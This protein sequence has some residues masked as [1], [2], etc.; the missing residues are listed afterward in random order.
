MYGYHD[1]WGWF[2]MVPM[3]LLW[4]AVWGG[5][6]YAAVRLGIQHGRQPSKPTIEQ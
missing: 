3:M 6:V 5:V 4:I 1:G 2:W